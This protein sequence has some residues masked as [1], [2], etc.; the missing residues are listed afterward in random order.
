M[1][2][3]LAWRGGLGSALALARLRDAGHEVSLLHAT[4]AGSRRERAASVPD[5]LV[6]EQAACLG[7]DLTLRAIDPARE[8]DVLAEALR[9]LA[10][11]AVA[12]GDAPP[13]WGENVARTAGVA[14]LWPLQN[15][16]RPRAVEEAVSRGVRG[17]VVACRPPLDPTFL[18]RFLDG[19]IMER[20]AARGPE[21]HD[22][23]RAFVVDG[24]GFRRRVDATAGETQPWG[25]GWRIDLGLRGC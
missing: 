25:E 10:P 14:A 3:V 8:E 2:I 6:E 4:D 23:W 5:F 7:L 13:A 15:V 12:F 1:R 11:D 24:P 19:G 20:M 9:A 18:G 22:A 21:A 16:P 17:F